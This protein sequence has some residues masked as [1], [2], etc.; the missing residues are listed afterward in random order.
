[1]KT[2]PNEMSFRFVVVAAVDD[3]GTFF[4]VRDRATGEQDGKYRQ[5]G[6]ALREAADREYKFLA[7]QGWR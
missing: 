2:T 3:H 7:S 5:E 4:M 6:T 1:M